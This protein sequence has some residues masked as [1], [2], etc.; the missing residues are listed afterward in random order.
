MTGSLAAGVQSSIGNVAAGSTFATLQSA[1]TGGA[2]LAA[3]NGVVQAAGVLM[4]AAGGFLARVGS[5]L[6]EFV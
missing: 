5:K 1:G 3:V 4:T 2:G 6:Q